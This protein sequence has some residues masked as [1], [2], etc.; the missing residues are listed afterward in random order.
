MYVCI[1][2][3]IYIVIDRVELYMYIYILFYI[4]DISQIRNHCCVVVV[5]FAVVLVN[6]NP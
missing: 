4:I 3:G 2:L 6:M 1:Y 5:V